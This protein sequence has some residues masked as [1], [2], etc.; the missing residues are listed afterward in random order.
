M[1]KFMHTNVGSVEST[2]RAHVDVLRNIQFVSPISGRSRTRRCH[3]SFLK[4]SCRDSRLSSIR[5]H[6]RRF[7]A[8]A[9][10]TC[11]KHCQTFSANR[12][13]KAN[14]PEYAHV[15]YDET[16]N[17]VDA[18][19]IDSPSSE[20]EVA[21]ATMSKF[22][23]PVRHTARHDFDDTDTETESEPEKF[24]DNASVE[25]QVCTLLPYKI[26]INKC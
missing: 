23:P 18:K 14:S 24:L 6:R 4:K 19:E 5:L 2:L 21:K 26:Y 20:E 16:V 10:A 12:A 25:E 17:V 3:H 11:D 15:M 22:N 13:R 8:V 7:C 9:M 1:K